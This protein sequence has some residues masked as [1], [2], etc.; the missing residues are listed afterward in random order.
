MS[1][2]KETSEP[3]ISA[4]QRDGVLFVLVV[5]L[6]LFAPPLVAWWASPNSP[7]YLPYLVWGCI[8]G[9]SVFFR[10]IGRHDL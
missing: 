4:Q 7:W 2:R 10:R 8:L 9:A 5:A 1:T 3:G 6:F